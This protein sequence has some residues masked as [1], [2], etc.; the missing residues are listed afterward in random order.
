MN[1]LYRFAGV[2]GQSL[3]DKVTNSLLEKSG[4]NALSVLEQVLRGVWFI[5][6]V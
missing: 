1:M 2:V 5:L 6:T 3:L 4:I